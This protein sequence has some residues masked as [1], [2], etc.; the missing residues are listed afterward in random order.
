MQYDSH[1]FNINIREVT[2]TSRI[3]FEISDLF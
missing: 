2:K 3:R 1:I